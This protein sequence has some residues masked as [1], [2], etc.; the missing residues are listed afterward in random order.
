MSNA[1]N[2]RIGLFFAQTRAK[3]T[4]HTMVRTALV[5]LIEI[6]TPKEDV[7]LA[8]ASFDAEI[9]ER[10]N[11]RLAAAEQLALLQTVVV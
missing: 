3:G 11:R 4:L 6:I 10:D 7:F 2:I 9:T 1:S 5:F 8:V